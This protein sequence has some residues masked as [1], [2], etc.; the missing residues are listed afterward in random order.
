M[1]DERRRP[2][3]PAPHA[4]LTDL[5]D[6]AGGQTEQSRAEIAAATAQALVSAARGD[7]DPERLV[8]LADS[9]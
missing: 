1:S 9:V 4:D 5:I 6:A 8:G 2:H 3:R 7:S